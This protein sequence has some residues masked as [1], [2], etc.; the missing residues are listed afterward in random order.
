MEEKEYKKDILDN[1]IL[2]VNEVLEKN[3]HKNG[4]EDIYLDI[5]KLMQKIKLKK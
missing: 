2:K 4:I 1:T 5:Q 3:K